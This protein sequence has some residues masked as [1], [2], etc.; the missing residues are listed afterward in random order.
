MRWIVKNANIL[1]QEGKILKNQNI[2]ID[3]N[4]ISAIETGISKDYLDIEKSIDAKEKLIIPGLINTHLHSHDRFDKGR[5]DNLPLEIW[6]VAYNPPNGKRDW[7]V[8]EIRLRTLLNCAELIK[9]GTTTVVDDVT[10]TDLQSQEKIDAVFQ[11]YNDAGLRAKVSISYS[12]KPYF[13]T[14]PFLDEFLPDS[15]K[16][17]LLQKSPAEPD[18]ILRLWEKYAKRWRNRVSFILSPSGPQRSTDEFLEKT[19]ALSR[20]FNLPVIIHVLETKI[21]EMTGYLFYGKSLVEH[22][23]SI[24]TLDDKTCLVH[25]VWVNDRDIEL[26]AQA[27]ANVIHNPISNLKLGS[28][29]API[30]KMLQAGINISLGTD[31]NAAN[32][33]VNIFESMKIGALINKVTSPD[34]RSWVGAVDVFKM[35][36]LGGAKSSGLYGK[37]GDLSKG[38]KADF[39]IFDLNKLSFLPPQNILYQLVFCENGE[40]IETVVI[41]GKIVFN[42]GKV[43]TINEDKLIEEVQSNAE[44]ILNKINV[45]SSRASEILP[46]LEKAYDK[47]IR[48]SQVKPIGSR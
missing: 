1:G 32:D 44:V 24:G 35:A 34:Y 46:Y 43:L 33:T 39:V 16:T 23:S 20:E 36:T 12:D 47:C 7:T 29:I 9:T 22:M 27:G 2:I 10:H 19:W 18:D 11:A 13:Q 21:Q 28:G 45:S 3:G 38:K 25:C 8:K 26:I 31:N 40:S 14:I 15:V 6:K 30:S 37:I 5:V 4:I 42:K 48:L 17:D 41:D